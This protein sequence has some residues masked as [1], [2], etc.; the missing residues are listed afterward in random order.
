V[1]NVSPHRLRDAF[2][3]MAVHRDDSTDSVRTL[4][5]QLGHASIGTTLRHR[6]VADEELKDWYMRLWGQADGY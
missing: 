3:V 5:E 2:A 4:Q 1:H 6:K